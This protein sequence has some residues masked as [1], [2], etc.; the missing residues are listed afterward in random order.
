MQH[1][2]ES[3][4]HPWDHSLAVTMTI[5]FLQ[6][7][8]GTSLRYHFGSTQTTLFGISQ[9]SNT[10]DSTRAAGGRRPTPGQ[11]RETAWRGGQELV[12]SSSSLPQDLNRGGHKQ[13]QG[14]HSHPGLLMQPSLGAPSQGSG[15]LCRAAA[16][17]VAGKRLALGNGQERSLSAWSTQATHLE[18]GSHVLALAGRAS[19]GRLWPGPGEEGGV[20]CGRDPQSP[21]SLGLPGAG[22]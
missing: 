16:S 4:L 21:W 18:A 13:L 9:T 10:K 7:W 1:T 15:C 20:S 2:L 12:L 22:G 5:R 11:L 19:W 3:T 14:H 17:S 8:P 6:E